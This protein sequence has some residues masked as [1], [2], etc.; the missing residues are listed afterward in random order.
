MAAMTHPRP[1]ALRRNGSKNSTF[2]QALVDFILI[3]DRFIEDITFNE[4]VTEHS[5]LSDAVVPTAPVPMI[6]KASPRRYRSATIS[7]GRAWLVPKTR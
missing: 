1:K 6:S 3:A 4:E 7:T 5:P 2:R